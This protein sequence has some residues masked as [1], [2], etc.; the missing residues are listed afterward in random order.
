MYFI[1]NVVWA[2]M[3]LFLFLVSMRISKDYLRKIALA[4][5]M[6]DNLKTGYDIFSRSENQLIRI[7]GS[8]VL[9]AVLIFIFYLFTLE[10]D[11]EKAIST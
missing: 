8:I 5:L 10:E 2:I 4:I 9:G 7:I 6:F 11:K 1:P 3:G